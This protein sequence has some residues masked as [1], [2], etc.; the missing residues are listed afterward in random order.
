MRKKI[1]KR[2]TAGAVS[3]I[4]IV[5]IAFLIPG[6]LI[7]HANDIGR[8][9]LRNKKVGGGYAVT[10]Q[11]GDISY[12]GEVY[13]SKSGLQSDEIYYIMPS[14]DGYMWF[15]GYAGITRYDGTNFRKL[16]TK[17]GLTSGR[18][19]FEDSRGRVFVGTN[20]DGVVIMEN[21][22]RYH[23][24]K[25]DGLPSSSIRSFAEDQSGNVYV[26]TTAGLAVIDKNN[27]VNPFNDKRLNG[28][29]VLRLVSD[30]EGIIYGYTK[31]GKAFKISNGGMLL[32]YDAEN[33]GI[34]TVTDIY[35][36]PEHES[37]VYI[38][39]P[40]GVVYCGILGEQ[41]ENMQAIKTPLNN[42][43]WI[44]YAC[45]R[46]W[47][48]SESEICYLDNDGKCKKV[49]N[50][51]VDNAI[52]MMTVDYQGNLWVA[53]SRLGAM[54]IV[55]NNFID[56]ND[57]AGLLPE[58]VGAT[59]SYNGNIYIGTDNGLRIVD[60]N[61]NVVENALTSYIGKNK[62]RYIMSDK[63]GN[64]WISTYSN[65]LGLV[66]YR[67]DGTFKNFTSANG[68]PG[69]EVRSTCEMSNGDIVV[70]TSFGLAIITDE[71][72]RKV[73]TKEDG[74]EDVAIMSV[75]VDDK[76]IIYAGTDGAGIVV[77][78]RENVMIIGENE[79]LTSDVIQRIK[80]DYKFKTMWIIASNSIMYIKNGERHTVS[81]FPNNNN[82]DMFFD[83]SDNVWVL[84]SYGITVVNE[85]LMQSDTVT[86]YKM[87]TI[88]NGLP[89]IPTR[90]GFGSTDDSGNLY[91]ATTSGVAKV[92][93][94]KYS[95][96]R[97]NLK[98]GVSAIYCDGEELL[99]DENGRYVIT[100][101]GSRVQIYPAIMDYTLSN[102]R[103]RVYLDGAKDEGI[104]ELREDLGI[105]EYTD[106]PYGKYTLHIQILADDGETAIQEATYVILKE[107]RLF[108]ETWVKVLALS[109]AGLIIAI[110]VWRILIG[111]IVKKQYAELEQ[112]RD[113][114]ERANTAKS[115]FLANMSHEIRTPIN[116]IMG[117][118]EMI[119]RE[120]TKNVPKPY[121][122]SVIN[123]AL[124]IRGAS[125]SLL[126]LIND[127]LDISKIESG[128]M[129]L[130]EQE[131][132][133]VE[134]LR[135]IIS[136]I[137]VRSAD[138]NL[139]FN[140]E[141]DEKLPKRLYGDAGKIKQIVLNLLTNAV[142][143][144][145]MGGFTLKVTVEDIND[146]STDLRFSV[147]DTGIGV[148]EEDMEK[149]FT[150]YERLDE[151][152]NSGIQGT[153]LGLD[154]SRRFAGLL[155]GNL[156]CESIYG[157][158][159]EFILTCTQKVVDREGVGEFTEHD[160]TEMRGPYVPQFVAP[161]AEILVVDDNP[162]NLTVIK[163]LLKPTKVFVTT[164]TSG[165][166]C[167]EKMRL[168][169]FYVVL[170]DHM[171]PGMDGIET[172][173]H[174]R[175]EFGDIPVYALT[176]NI[177]A[178]GDEFY[179]SHGFNGYLSKPI[180]SF[181]LERTIKSHL[182]KEI[183]MDPSEGDYTAE[184]TS[185]PKEYEWLY[186]IRE[187]NVEDGIKCSGGVNT[188]I[189]SINDFFETIDH[190]GGVIETA[191]ETGD[192][193]FYTIKVHALKTSARIIG[194]NDLSKKA[195]ALEDAGKSG[196]LDYIKSEN[197]GF[198]ADFN[199]FKTLLAPLKDMGSDNE[200]PMIDDAELKDAYEALKEL[201]PQMD[202]DSVEMILNQLEE[203]KLPEKDEARFE[204]LRTYFK[205][206]DWDKLNE[207][208]S[209]VE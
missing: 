117:M 150:A 38:G 87:Y 145:D 71:K 63:K 57:R 129:H 11:L 84:S 127:I 104:T 108:E 204:E 99:P 163:G 7:S 76:N 44:L 23:Y 9:D 200:K 78:N 56:V 100:S 115:R 168:K 121:L 42:I 156:W 75:A 169:K 26:A 112:A 199:A 151:Q 2:L 73:Y 149:L 98:I 10:G 126:G 47:I 155:G 62:V 85:K 90:T 70:A 164:A 14:K 193:D 182:P 58:A 35:V 143:Y 96:I 52:E 34:S 48:A 92:N 60:E 183:M 41:A 134:F 141:I 49:K 31:S 201:I 1:I 18:A 22:K 196:N 51:P 114:A 24:A 158:G 153:G 3:V 15:A 130:V 91:I 125:E 118:D 175:E 59:L 74:L 137:R 174:I 86:D 5:S 36:N 68:L 27:R 197:Q 133:T 162:M 185:L 113:E 186:N 132:G 106:L 122:M 187:I 180:D 105:L 66:L 190:T 45:D 61:Y 181:A 72:V 43:K 20:G 165:E 172:L 184:D 95:D 198:M 67:A 194:A 161:D 209:E 178:G 135:A 179:K 102:P 50:L 110:V 152:K 207:I 28:E 37:K 147:K 13:D 111:T 195:Q 94:N 30:S 80:W 116:T 89:G 123:Y 21:G 109:I 79:G 146:V 33:L 208:I 77:I 119:L 32:L 65:T 103:I 39:G 124:D 136:M 29:R 4:L 139:E 192:Y 206:V 205:L 82:I 88:A 171:M 131:Y 93:I 203:Y 144:T 53:S 83:S 97:D 170:L 188:Y 191:F 148:K 154:I 157:K 17:D 19:I 120:D 25:R 128:K 12:V 176:A 142:K 16:D 8:A 173:S 46:L 177:A 54:K 160:D 69:N 166:E 107:A 189:Q 167:L 40:D 64:L 140:V 101:R 138:K 81:T 202:I 6:A 159:S 55:P